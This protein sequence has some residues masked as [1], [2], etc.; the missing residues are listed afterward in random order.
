[1]G[2]EWLPGLR[3]AKNVGVNIASQI[4]ALISEKEGVLSTPVAALEIQVRNELHNKS[5]IKPPGN[6][7]PTTSLI[8]ITQFNRDPMVKAW[9]LK[10]ANGKCEC[11]DQN[12]PFL[13]TD[14]LPF[15]EVHHVRKLADQGSDAISNAV[16][17]CPNCHRLLHYGQNSADTAKKLY[18]KIKRLIRE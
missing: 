9:V 10:Q 13:G 2:K 16:A 3:P 8:S 5:L 7:S 11:C 17:L 4:E 1:M 15:L 6:K 12:A 14:G 18:A